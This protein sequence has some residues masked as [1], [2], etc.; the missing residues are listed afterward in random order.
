MKGINF[1]GIQFYG[2]CWKGFNFKGM[3][4]GIHI[5]GFYAR[6]L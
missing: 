3:L 2:I 4:E 5:K 6:I 1:E